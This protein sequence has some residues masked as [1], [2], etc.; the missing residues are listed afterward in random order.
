MGSSPTRTRFGNRLRNQRLKAP[1]YALKSVTKV[2]NLIVLAGVQTLNQR[3]EGS[4]PSTPT[5]EINNIGTERSYSAQPGGNTGVIGE[6]L[7][8]TIPPGGPFRH[9]T[10]WQPYTPLR[11]RRTWI[12]CRCCLFSS[13]NCYFSSDPVGAR[14]GGCKVSRDMNQA[15]TDKPAQ[16]APCVKHRAHV[17]PGPGAPTLGSGGGAVLSM[18]IPTVR[19]VFLARSIKGLV[20]KSEWVLMGR[21]C[22]GCFT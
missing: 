13:C 3:V 19:A 6:P 14:V 18:L 21:S 17:E 5:N 9:T 4:S 15:D 20:I 7:W 22:P 1:F 10:S 8:R 2:P 11:W 16:V 12:C